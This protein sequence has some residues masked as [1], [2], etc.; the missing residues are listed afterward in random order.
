MLDAFCPWDYTP[1]LQSETAVLSIC[2]ACFIHIDGGMV[3]SFKPAPDS[4]NG[5]A[6]L[7]IPR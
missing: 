4:T 2:I 6:V 7:H 3:K 5:H 1:I